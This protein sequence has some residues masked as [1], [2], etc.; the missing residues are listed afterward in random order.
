MVG[1]SL[2][3]G[4]GLKFWAK[5]GGR[6]FCVWRWGQ[7]FDQAWLVTLMEVLNMVARASIFEGRD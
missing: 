2:V 7:N 5:Y 1:S 3:F 4:V 6:G